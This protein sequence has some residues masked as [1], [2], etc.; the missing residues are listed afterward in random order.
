MT[1]VFQAQKSDI[2]QITDFYQG[3]EMIPSSEY[4]MAVYKQENKVITIFNSLKVTLQ[5]NDALEDYLMWSEILGFE[6]K[7]TEEIQKKD[8][9]IK[10]SVI[11]KSIIGS[12]EVGTGDFYGPVVVCAAYIGKNEISKLSMYPIRDSKKLTDELILS[13]GENLMKDVTH[14]VLVL[15]N[16]KYNNL[17]KEGYNLNKIKAYL[18]NHAIRKLILKV[19]DEIDLVVIDE[20]CSKENYFDY[21]KDIESYKNITFLQKAEDQVLSVG[22]ASIIARYTFLKEMDK[23]SLDLGITLPK[24]SGIASDLIG[25]RIALEKGFDIFNEIAK[26]HFKNMEKIKSLMK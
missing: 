2:P 22:V 21:L 13:I 26:T 17:T 19:K 15:P 12:D 3:F 20:F 4:I 16:P 8:E 24:G 9:Q 11:Q 5:G 10:V 7:S 6:T 18:H 25:K 1:Y 23:L 14:Q